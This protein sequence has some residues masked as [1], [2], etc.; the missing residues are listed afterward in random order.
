MRTILGGKQAIIIVNLTKESKMNAKRTRYWVIVSFLAAFI[1]LIC[2]AGMS[3]LAQ[4][5][6]SKPVQIVVPFRA[7]G[8]ADRTFRLFAPYL[9]KELGVPVNVINIAGGGG[10]V[11]WSQMARWCPT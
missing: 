11:A 1:F 8:G 9:S 10:W 7:G 2:G 4:K 3:A 6:P 5:F